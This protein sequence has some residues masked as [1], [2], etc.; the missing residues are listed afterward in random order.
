MCCFKTQ[1]FTQ[2]KYL[3]FHGIPPWKVC[4]YIFICSVNILNFYQRWMCQRP[5]KF[6]IW[7]SESYLPPLTVAASKNVWISGFC[8]QM[9]ISQNPKKIYN[10]IHFLKISAFYLY[11]KCHFL[12]KYVIYFL[13]A[14]C[15]LRWSTICQSKIWPFWRFSPNIFPISQPKKCIGGGVL[16]ASQD[17]FLKS[18]KIATTEM[19]HPPNF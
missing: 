19:V 3:I 7:I 17:T 11:S 5:F 8:K 12:R 18:V 9:L 16:E 14:T 1:I 10:H 6:H 4:F 15:F 13:Y 2:D